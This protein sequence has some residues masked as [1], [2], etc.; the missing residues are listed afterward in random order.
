[1]AKFIKTLCWMRTEQVPLLREI[2]ALASLQLVSVGTAEKGRA[3]ALAAELADLS[4]AAPSPPAAHDDLRAALSVTEAS[5]VLLADT[6]GFGESPADAAALEAAARRGTRIVSFEFLPPTTATLASTAWQTTIEGVPLWDIVRSA[7]AVDASATMRE[8]LATLENFGEVSA[9]AVLCAAAPNAGSLGARLA[10]AMELIHAVAG[11]PE[12]IS[13]SHVAPAEMRGLRMGSLP[14]SH[15]SLSAA[16]R[17]DANRSA[18]VLAS[19]QTGPWHRGVTILGPGGRLR[20]W[21]EGF[22]WTAPDGRVLD[23]QRTT[24]APSDVDPA[25]RLIAAAIAASSEPP[26]NRAA[27]PA[28]LAMAEAAMLSTRTGQPESPA[29]LRRA[30]EAP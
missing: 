5:L 15:G 18:S 6:A 11:E 9:V 19:D 24:A 8:G 20:L 28:I 16:L 3:S 1:M 21:D 30:A 25:A 27:A 2:A 7:A 12:L 26:A 29:T 13:A 23:E 4:P 14:E 17:F 10:S 22:V